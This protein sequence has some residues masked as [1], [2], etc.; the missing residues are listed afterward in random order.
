MEATPLPSGCGAHVEVEA[1]HYD[2]SITINT[3][4]S[5]DFAQELTL[6]IYNSAGE[7]IATETYNL[8]TGNSFKY[9]VSQFPTGAYYFNITTNTGNPVFS[10][11]FIVIE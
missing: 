9:D 3:S 8:S 1:M 2:N 7:T 4:L 6:H 5:P 11:K 10:N